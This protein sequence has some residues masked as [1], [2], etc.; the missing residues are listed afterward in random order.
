MKKVTKNNLNMELKKSVDC[1]LKLFKQK[2]DSVY[3]FGSFVNGKFNSLSDVDVCFFGDFSFEDKVR[4][5][6]FFGDI[7]DVC[8]FDELPIYIKIR[9][10][11]EGRLLYAKNK[12]KLMSVA[13]K[14]LCEYEDFKPLIQTGIKRMFG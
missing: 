5:R 7:F 8:F 13:F 3:L 4:I 11:R 10:F 12:K 9:V 2:I 14:T 1:S 6:S